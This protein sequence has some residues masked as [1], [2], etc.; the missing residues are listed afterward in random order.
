MSKITK[1]C[2]I[3]TVTKII[4]LKDGEDIQKYI[5]QFEDEPIGMPV[6]L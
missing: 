6:I 4:N 1:L 2:L 5:E 3:G